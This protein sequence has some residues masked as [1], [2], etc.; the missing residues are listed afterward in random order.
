MNF[1]LLV[2]TAVLFG[3]CVYLFI[4]LVDVKAQLKIKDTDKEFWFMQY[5]QTEAVNEN[6]K[7]ENMTVNEVNQKLYY[8]MY[9]VKPGEKDEPIHG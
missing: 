8:E 4:T 3:I 7:R 6:L 5:K 2:S 9:G 1:A